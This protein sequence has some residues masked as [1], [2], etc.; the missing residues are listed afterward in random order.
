M[1]QKYVYFQ[2]DF[3][4]TLA[5]EGGWELPFRLTFFTGTLSKSVVATYDGTIYSGCHVDGNGNL[6]VAFVDQQMGMGALKMGKKIYASP[7]DYAADIAMTTSPYTN[8]KDYEGY[9]VQ[10]TSGQSAITPCTPQQGEKGEKGDQ[11]EIGPQGPRGP[12]GLQGE[13]GPKGLPGD[14]INNEGMW[15]AIDALQPK[16]FTAG[17]KK[18]LEEEGLWEHTIEMYPLIYV[19]E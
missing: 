2:S 16:V 4:V 15:E 5:Q 19:T 6:V 11:G 18:V 13:R 17:E 14:A 12:R 1:G 8:V 3:S 7:D 9:T 10:L